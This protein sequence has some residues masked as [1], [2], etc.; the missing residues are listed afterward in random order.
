MKNYCTSQLHLPIITYS[1]I[2]YKP[3]L[4]LYYVMNEYILSK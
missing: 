1:Y 3:L 4:P 2:T